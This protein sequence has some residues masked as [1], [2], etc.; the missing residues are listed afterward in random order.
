MAN[1]GAATLNSAA[2][3]A[4]RSIPGEGIKTLTVDNGKDFAGH[5]GLSQKLGCVLYFAYPY[6]SWERGLN[7]HPNGLLRH[8]LPKGTSFEGLT[9]R[10]LDRII[11]KINNRPRKVLGYRT[12]HEVFS[13]YL[14][15]LQI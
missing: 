15:A 5:K 4:F 7:E 6:H 3:Q 14:F 8:Y 9:Q 1:Q 2:V 12:P 13:E 10:R 11:E